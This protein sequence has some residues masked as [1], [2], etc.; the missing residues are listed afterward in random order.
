MAEDRRERP[1][2]LVLQSGETDPLEL[3][4]I[5]L[6]TEDRILDES[7]EYGSV[8]HEDLGLCGILSDPL[9][10]LESLLQDGNVGSGVFCGFSEIDVAEIL[11]S[12][13]SGILEDIGIL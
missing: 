6:L 9:D 11:K 12:D 1:W 7:F 13:L 10:G 5:V 8:R 4:H 2:I 3:D